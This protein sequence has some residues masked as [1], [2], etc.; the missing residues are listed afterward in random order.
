[1]L[2]IYISGQ[3]RTIF[4]STSSYLP[5][6]LSLRSHSH[7][8]NLLFIYLTSVCL[9]TALYLH[10]CLYN[11][12]LSSSLLFTSDHRHHAGQDT[13]TALCFFHQAT[14]PFIQDPPSTLLQ[15]DSS[16]AHG[17]LGSVTRC[18]SK[19]PLR[20]RNN[21][22]LRTQPSLYHLSDARRLQ[23]VDLRPEAMERRAIL[24]KHPQH[25]RPAAVPARGSCQERARLCH[26]VLP[27][28]TSR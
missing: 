15:R 2:S 24:P 6:H 18:G 21:S 23:E 11:Q 19:R 13:S 20:L 5:R 17:Y 4:D 8:L 7:S 14:V 22:L 28:S 9:V 1:M 27:A 25:R 3:S 12:F 10:S 26:G 16:S